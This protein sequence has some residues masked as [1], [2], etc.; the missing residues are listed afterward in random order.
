MAG[1]SDGVV[2]MVRLQQKSDYT[3]LEMKLCDV[4]K[5]HN[6]SVTKLSFNEELNLLASGVSGG[7]YLQVMIPVGR[8]AISV[9][10]KL[11]KHG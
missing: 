1:F 6:A 5:P 10:G 3:N 11:L 4:I 9:R 8:Y 7:I 2:R